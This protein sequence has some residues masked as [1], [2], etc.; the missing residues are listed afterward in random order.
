MNTPTISSQDAV[1]VIH[2]TASMEQVD[3]QRDSVNQ[4]DASIIRPV[5]GSVILTEK[6]IYSDFKDDSQKREVINL[7]ETEYA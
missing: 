1:N 2:T 3:N 7:L 6:A 4:S 5:T